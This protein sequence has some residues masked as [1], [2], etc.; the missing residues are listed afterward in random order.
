[1]KHFARLNKHP[2]TFEQF[3]ETVTPYLNA[4][5]LK[6]G[7]DRDE[8][9]FC[10]STRIYLAL[11]THKGEYHLHIDFLA[12]TSFGCLVERGS[13]NPES[14]ADSAHGTLH[15]GCY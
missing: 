3:T 8:H 1:M 9:F 11:L 14:A 2:I 15:L 6:L 12:G 7:T 13:T 4:D 5:L 10:A